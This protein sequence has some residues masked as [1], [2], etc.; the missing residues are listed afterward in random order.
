MRSYCQKPKVRY[1]SK[2]AFSLV[3]AGTA[4]AI[5]ALV[6]TSVLVVVN[7]AMAS[8]SDLTL[9][10][11]AFEIARENMEKILLKDSVTEMVEYG[12]SEKY[13]EIDRLEGRLYLSEINISDYEGKTDFEVLIRILVIIS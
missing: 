5:L 1:H 9:R 2:K 12:E 6:C 10:M 13:P 4:L 3:E 11:H 7:R 8:A